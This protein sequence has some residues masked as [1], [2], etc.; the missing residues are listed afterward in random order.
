MGIEEL[1]L[2]KAR[3]D[4]LQKGLQKGF[5]KDKQIVRNLIIKHGWTDEQITEVAEVSVDFVKKVRA[6]LNL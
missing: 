1:L 3:H 6:S 5:Q 4:G 2:E